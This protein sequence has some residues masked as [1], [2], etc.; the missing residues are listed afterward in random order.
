VAAISLG[1]VTALM[2]PR[3]TGWPVGVLSLGLLSA[4]LFLQ[5]RA[6]LYVGTLVFTLN[7]L[8]QLVLL[9][10]VY[11]LMKWVLGLA[12]GVALIWV[13]A[14]FERRRSQWLQIT[15]TWLDNLDGW[16]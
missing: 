8:N 16:Q 12:V 15:Q 13:A 14:D 3:W 7:A 4:G 6:F 9:N 10:A 2:L 11:P 1:L 5:I